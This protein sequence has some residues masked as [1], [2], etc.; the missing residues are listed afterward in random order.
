M[1]NKFFLPFVSLSLILFILVLFEITYAQDTPDHGHVWS[2][3][4]GRFV[5]IGTIIHDTPQ[6]Q[7]EY[8]QSLEKEGDLE[9]AAEAYNNLFRKFPNTLLAQEALFNLGLIQEQQQKYLEAFNNYQKIIDYYPHTDKLNAITE[10]QFKI[11]NL[12]LSGKRGKIFNIPI[13]PAIP[14]AIKVF[15]KISTNAPFSLYGMKSQFSLAIAYKKKGQFREAINQFKKFVADYPKSDFRTEAFFQIAEVTYIMSQRKGTDEKL[16]KEAQ[17]ILIDYVQRYP[18]TPNTEKAKNMLASLQQKDAE[19]TYKIARY[20]ERESYLD[21]AILYYKELVRLY[22]NT[23]WAHKAQKRLDSF[24]DPERF[25][26]EGRKVLDE[27]LDK[28][29]D[30]KKELEVKTSEEAELEQGAVQERIKEVKKDI[31]RLDKKKNKEIKIRWEALRRKKDELKER[32]KKLENKEKRLKKNP[33]DDLEE[34]IKRWEESLIAEEYVL[35]MEERELLA[36]QQRLGIKRVIPFFDLIT[37]RGSKIESIKQFK[38]KEFQ[39]ISEQETVLVERKDELYSDLEKLEGQKEALEDKLT[40]LLDKEL[41]DKKHLEK[42]EIELLEEKKK[43]DILNRK[44]KDKRK[45]YKKTQGVFPAVLSLPKQSVAGIMKPFTKSPEERLDAE[46]AA[47]K[48]EIEELK[49]NINVEEGDIKRF[50]GLLKIAPG[51]NGKKLKSIQEDKAEG[52]VEEKDSPKILQ[53]KIDKRKAR[54]QVMSI[55]KKINQAH[56]IIEDSQKKKSVLIRELEDTVN[57]IKQDK[58]SA[59][60]KTLSGAAKPLLVISQG[61]NAF[62]FGLKDKAQTVEK[63]ADK[64]ERK[65]QDIEDSE[66]IRT[67]QKEIDELDNLIKKT[68]VDIIAYEFE[69]ENLIKNLKGTIDIIEEKREKKDKSILRKTINEKEK[70]IKDLKAELV[71]KE[72][73]LKSLALQKDENKE[74]QTSSKKDKVKI[75]DSGSKRDKR[76]KLES[77]LNNLEK[78]IDKQRQIVSDNEKSLKI[79]RKDIT[80]KSASK[81]KWKIFKTADEKINGELNEL[82]EAEFDILNDIEKIVKEQQEIL[83]DKQSLMQEK[84]ERV[85]KRMQR[86]EKYQ[87]RELDKMKEYQKAIYKEFDD[88]NSFSQTL[89][90]ELNQID[91]R[92]SGIK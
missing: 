69:L 34:A 52:D 16:I 28:L 67:Y 88:L 81:K 31:K 50:T 90:D 84:I 9:T 78:Q 82:Q 63:K 85:K 55:E 24:E 27:K 71:V 5:K 7:F 41:T 80:Q 32:R 4:L 65:S 60:G 62:I 89:K 10:H 53:E 83:N 40:A 17:E 22:P 92:L 13:R 44:Y 79:K 75:D 1:S 25:L 77:E 59:I 86:M 76:I 39:N 6:G 33:S 68:E 36:L 87:D 74:K 37:G 29:Y 35:E 70:Y 8:A 43:L 61:V 18:N 38:E 12:F 26:L 45:E 19:R 58:S 57:D 42:D 47:T 73:S 15:E 91:A 21:S 51:T 2:S 66:I 30:Q 23:T 46:I 11:G 54:K 64:L 20:Y 48:F 56:H 72:K 49:K 14:L 3:D